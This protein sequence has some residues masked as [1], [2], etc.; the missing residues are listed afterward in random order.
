MRKVQ[1]KYKL[2]SQEAERQKEGK[3]NEQQDE[4]E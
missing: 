4:K 3:D 2:A 1:S